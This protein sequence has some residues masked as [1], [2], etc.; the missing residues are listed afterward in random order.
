MNMSSPSKDNEKKDTTREELRALEA[1]IRD[2][3]RFLP[4]LVCYVNPF[5]TILEVN[6]SF[7]RISGYKSTEIIGE[8]LEKFFADPQEIEK[9]EKEIS[10]KGE[11]FGLEIDFL[12][13]EKNEI[14]VILSAMA[15]KDEK[16]D[17]TGFFLSIV[18]ITERKRV[19]EA[20][21]ESERRYRALFESALDGV[22]VID[23]ETMKVVLANEALAKLFGFDSAEDVIGMN[24]IDFVPP[25]DRDRAIRIIA[26][27]MFTRD[28]RQANEFRAITRDNREIWIRAIGARIKYKGRLAGLVSL[29]DITKRRQVEE[30]LR[31]SEASYRELANSI[32]DIFFAFDKDLR[33]TYWNRASEDL[34]GIPAKDAIGKSLYDIFPNTSQTRIAEKV[35]RDVLRTQQ[36]QSFV[37]EYQFGGKD[38]VFEIIAYP[39]K[40]GL[41]VFVKDITE[42]KR[43]EERYKTVLQTSMDGF[44]VTDIQGR[45][46]EV[47][48]AYCR[49]I[50]YSR[51]E[52]LKMGIQ[53][54]EAIEKPEVT[55]ARIQ[56]IM[57]T[58]SDRFETRHRC[59]DGRIVDVE[60][61][62]DYLDVEDGQLFVF[63]RDITERKQAEEALARERYL[64]RAF[65]DNIPDSIYFKDKE[66]RFI[67]VSKAKAKHHGVNP[68]DFA[69]KTDFDFYSEEQARRMRE[70]D[71]YV[72]KTKEP[73]IGKEEKVIRPDGAARWHSVTKIP[74][75]DEEGNIIGTMGISRDITDRKRAE[76]ALK[77]SEEKFR[78][79]AE[80]SPS[81]IFINKGGRVVYANKKCEEVMGHTRDEFYSADFDFFSLI[82]PE[83]RK[84]V[85]TSFGMHTGG[86]EVKPYEY[87]LVTKEGRRVEAILI[88]R[89]IDY[90]GEKAILGIITDITEYRK[91]ERERIAA[92]KT[93]AR[94][95]ALNRMKDE[96]LSM[97]SHEL[98]T[99]LTSISSFL[100]LMES[101]KLGKITRK[102]EEGLAAISAGVERLNSSIDKLLMISK[103]ELGEMKLEMKNLRLADLIQNTVKKMEPLAKQKRIALTQKIAELPLVRAD[104]EQLTEV[105]T[106]LVDNAIKFTPEGGEVTVEAKKEKDNILVMVE[107]TGIGIAKKNMPQLFT[108]FFQVDHSVPGTG[109]GLS[110]CKKI[111]LGHGG[112]IWAKSTLGRGSTFFFTLPIKK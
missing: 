63:L 84:L 13:K 35:Y 46:L 109:L 86:E 60:V 44:W 11:I 91:A 31:E 66:H 52:L 15:R 27:D 105:L 26:E 53:D 8:N 96:F 72:V 104:E 24:P 77:E 40:R 57:K 92:E 73:I 54:V 28:L 22:F 108:K 4:L 5:Y 89:L 37:N 101:G 65:M 33:Y 32:T 10:E 50:G 6:E 48:D 103:L 7:E 97:T 49:L 94:L 79:L 68:K 14:P 107:D 56:K 85:K 67:V 87:T 19:E 90:E 80:Q 111:V 3:Q 71:D 81:I 42:R 2:F 38:F 45:F 70:D 34:T 99:P 30:A 29:Y 9:I 98:R 12:T 61:S 76:D 74:Y 21:R 78:A 18:D 95:K 41:S 93:T 43:A 47:N 17:I 20:L 62:V 55:A 1:Y 69:G 36:S 88:T 64:M 59:K 16:G 23:A 51:D 110:I 82:A 58:G 39:S 112:R 25:D 75:R 106:N 102:Q 100:Q 83:C